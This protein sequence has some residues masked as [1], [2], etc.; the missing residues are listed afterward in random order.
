[1]NYI[2]TCTRCGISKG[3]TGFFANNQ[4]GVCRQCL[5]R[6]KPTPTH[7]T[8]T[9]CGLQQPVTEF[10][11]R[12]NRKIG[13]SRCRTCLSAEAAIKTDGR[14]RQ[15]RNWYLMTRRGITL[16]EYERRLAEQGGVCAICNEAPE[17]SNRAAKLLHVD[18]NHKTGAVRGLLCIRCNQVIGHARDSVAMILKMAEYVRVHDASS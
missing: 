8:C 15:M 5:N 17:G 14:Y 6:D 9:K 11:K 7:K 13:T 4:D 1:M 12:Y 10:Y 3:H 16:E 18:H 2:K